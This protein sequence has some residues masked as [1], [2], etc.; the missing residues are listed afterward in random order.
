M[1]GVY[2]GLLCA[3]QAAEE[4]G[5][6]KQQ[7]KDARRAAGTTPKALAK[8][9]EVLRETW[10]STGGH[11]HGHGHHL[12]IPQPHFYTHEM[13]AWVVPALNLAAY[14]YLCGLGGLGLGLDL[15]KQ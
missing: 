9:L 10:D 7:R 15:F 1:T 13:P 6:L 8:Q 3:L 4:W 2:T 11:G 12:Q 5:Q 14:W